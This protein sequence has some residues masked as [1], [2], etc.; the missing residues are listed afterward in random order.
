MVVA[1]SDCSLKRRREIDEPHL[2]EQVRH[3]HIFLDIV[4]FH[5]VYLTQKILNKTDFYGDSK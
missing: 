1:K 2:S 4:I 3:S 5:S